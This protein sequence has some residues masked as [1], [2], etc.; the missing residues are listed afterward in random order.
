MR[1]RRWLWIGIAVAIAVLGFSGARIA[2]YNNDIS[3]MFPKDSLSGTMYGVAQKSRLTQ[4]IQLEI[5]TGEQDAVPNLLDNFDAISAELEA[6][7][8]VASVQCRTAINAVDAQRD[9]V[10]AI[11][12]TVDAK[13]LDS[14]DARNALLTSLRLLSI[15]GMPADAVRMDPFGFRLATLQK[16]SAFQEL[17]GYK[18]SMENGILSDESNQRVLCIIRAEFANAPTA[19]DIQTLFDSIT[20]IVK[21]HIPNAKTSIVSPLRHQLDNEISVRR[22]IFAVSF[23]SIVMLVLLFLI[24][25]RRSLDA[26]W[27]PI[28]PLVASM[29]I[30][31]IMAF[32]FDSICLY[33]LGICGGLAGLAVDQEIHVY[34]A[35]TGDSPLK[36]V[37]GILKPLTWSVLT[38]ACIFLMLCTTGIEAYLQIG[39]FAASTLL[40]NLL[41]AVLLLPTLLKKRP[42][43][44]NV[45]QS[46]A[47][48]RRKSVL[49]VAIWIILTLFSFAM[50]PHIRFNSELS[51]ID[52]ASK[53]TIIDEEK[54]INR[55]RNEN[56]GRII[57]VTGNMRDDVLATLQT[58][59]KELN[60][61]K[62]FSIADIWPSQETRNSNFASW[63]AKQEK[64]KALSDQ[65]KK[66]AAAFQLPPE[67]F[68]PFDDIMAEAMKRPD[69]P[70]ALHQTLLSQLLTE[71]KDD[72]SSLMFVSNDSMS[73]EAILEKLQGRRNAALLSSDA[74]RLATAHDV[75]PRI[76]RLVFAVVPALFI[77]LLFI[78]RKPSHL[79]IILLPGATAFLWSA[80]LAATIGIRPNIVSLFAMV[81]LTGLVLDYGIFALHAMRYKGSSTPLALLLSA[82]TTILTTGALVASKHPVLFHTGL[83]LSTGILFTAVTALLLIPA[84]NTILSKEAKP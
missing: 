84:L 22:D 79:A 67:F 50:L 45:F 32:V 55:W 23:T 82:L 5:D 61:E 21:K 24:V 6:L 74:F 37:A 14:L 57:A 18:A 54:I 81:M 60:A 83:T 28:L 64:L 41:L 80:G 62:S 31:G 70:P 71:S 3:F 46:F 26:V 65:L 17:G 66:E 34:A 39:I 42:A 78:T 44:K 15:P 13:V 76:K 2:K 16:L 33:V 25:Y 43:A 9:I 30:T 75:K 40:L 72:A 63:Q 11:P 4:S 48:S 59:A 7:P 53:E 19:K 38:S 8:N 49:L 10:L 47:P 69:T 1:H 58:V 29:L 12:Y 20:G 35:C 68:K 36:N 73:T 27:L 77:M 56:A 51:A 52:G